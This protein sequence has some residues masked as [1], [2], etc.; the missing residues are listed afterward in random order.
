MANLKEGHVIEPQDFQMGICYECSTKIRD[1]SQKKVSHCPICKKWFC[2]IHLKPKFPYFVDW[3][4]VFDVQGNP[5]IKALFYAEYE[6]KDGHADLVYLRNTI[7]ENNRQKK[8]QDQVIQEKI[9]RMIMYGS[10]RSS[11]EILISKKSKTTYTNGFGRAFTV[12]TEV[13]SNRIYCE[14]LKS[15]NSQGEINEI[16]NDY[17]FNGK[18]LLEKEKKIA[19]LEKATATKKHW[20]QR[21]R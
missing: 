1:S 2:D 11:L 18:R 3:D 21:K 17:Y 13:Y 16:L 9:D 7:E 8:I 5:E 15:A 14:K 19:Q 12:P 4:T 6:R 10:S 20:W